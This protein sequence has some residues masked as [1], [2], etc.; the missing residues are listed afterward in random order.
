MEARIYAEDPRHNFMPCPG[1]I[2]DLVLPHGPGVRVDCG[3]ASGFEVPRHYDPMI[4]KIAVWGE[5][6]ERARRRLSR[7]LGETAV[8]GITTNTAFL[9]QLLELPAFK[10]GHYH[11]GTV[12]E[13]L[14]HPA[15][16]PRR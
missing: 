9:R 7:A 3:V 13:A 12:A 16:S 4:A 11:T 2:V 10:A 8:K 6:R 5:D 1:T 14:A 15:P